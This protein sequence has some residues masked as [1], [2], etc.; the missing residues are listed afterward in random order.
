L[1]GYRGDG[2]LWFSDGG[3]PEQ[4]GAHV[5]EAPHGFANT[6]L[7]SNA[8]SRVAWLECTK[9]PLQ[10]LVVFDT[11]SMEEVVREP[12]SLCERTAGLECSLDELIGDHVYLTDG[13][14][15][16]A[17]GDGPPQ[18]RAHRPPPRPPR[19]AGAKG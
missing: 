6:A 3:A 1:A 11:G 8:G 14:T 2:R 4:I 19:L 10:S 5:C 13:Y 7:T 9:D 12:L 18:H 15:R 16:R 17:G